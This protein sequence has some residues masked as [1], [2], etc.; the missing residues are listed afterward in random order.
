[1]SGWAVLAWGDDPP[2]PP[3]GHGPGDDP[4]GPPEEG[5]TRGRTPKPPLYDLVLQAAPLAF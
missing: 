5:T 3:R 1:M 4:P 2:K